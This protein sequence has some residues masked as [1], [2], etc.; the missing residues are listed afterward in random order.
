MAEVIVLHV[1]LLKASEVDEL[2]H[3]K[4]VLRNVEHRQVWKQLEVFLLH[5]DDVLTA[6]LGFDG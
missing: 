4:M 6:K 2:R 3:Q 1:K 5:V